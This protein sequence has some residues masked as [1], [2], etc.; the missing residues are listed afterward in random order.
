MERV[1]VHRARSRDARSRDALKSHARI[2]EV[3]LTL[4]TGFARFAS[5]ERIAT[6]DRFP[7]H[8]AITRI[9]EGSY[10]FRAVK[11]RIFF[12]ADRHATRLFAQVIRSCGNYALRRARPSFISA[13]VT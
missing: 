13:A 5:L 12:C 6:L 8:A 10:R 2:R 9:A 1:S 4:V 3:V 11:Q 7:Q